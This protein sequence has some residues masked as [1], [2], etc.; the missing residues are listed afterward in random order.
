[1]AL[2]LPGVVDVI[3][4]K[5]IPGKKFRTMLGYDEE[6][7]V[8]DEVTCVGQMVC[9]VVADSKAHAKRGAAAVK[10]SYEDL[11]DRIFTIEEAIEKESFF[12]PKRLIERGDVEKGLREAEQVYE[13][14]IRIGGQEHFYLETQSF[15]VIPVGEEKEMKVYLSTQHPT[16]TQ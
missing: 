4:T 11:Q 12:L 2:K 14:E 9:A 10:I 6:L 13:G 15:L 5:D 3:T 16:F 1:E 7:L 8:E